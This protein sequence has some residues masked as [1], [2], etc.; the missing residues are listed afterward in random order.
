MCLCRN[1]T[2]IQFDEFFQDG[3]GPGTIRVANTTIRDGWVEVEWDNGYVN[4]YRSGYEGK[5]DVT[6]QP[7]S[8]QFTTID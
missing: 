3:D 8:R 4:T 7:S 6:I 2:R 5:R 1:D